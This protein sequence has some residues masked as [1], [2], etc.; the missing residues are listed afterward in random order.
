MAAPESTKFQVN[1]KLN[2]GTLINIY[3]TT[4]A[5]LESSLVS[6]ADLSTLISTTGTA[7]GATTPS[8]GGGAISYA[9]KALGGT[10]V[11]S[12][13][14]GDTVTDK[15]GTV[16]TYE[17]ADAPDCI[18]GKMVFAVGISQKGKPYKGWFDPM[19]GPK[20]MRKPDGYVAVDPIFLK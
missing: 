8:S 17:R 3:A 15:Y 4:Q 20:P 16:W 11:V 14:S 19:K 9:K 7:L 2:D 6:V 12:D 5:E 13:T 18:N 10:T 1:Y